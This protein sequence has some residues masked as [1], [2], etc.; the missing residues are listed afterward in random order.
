VNFKIED[1]AKKLDMDRI[2]HMHGKKQKK[3]RSGKPASL[4]TL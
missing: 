3:L 1:L 4:F 2:I